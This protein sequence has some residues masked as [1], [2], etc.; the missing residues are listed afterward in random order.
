MVIHNPI[1]YVKR[2]YDQN[3]DSEQQNFN[4]NN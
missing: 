1:A 4:F 2:G 3:D